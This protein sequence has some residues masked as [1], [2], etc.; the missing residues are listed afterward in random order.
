M[1]KVSKVPISVNVTVGV[2]GTSVYNGLAELKIR[3]DK[4]GMVALIGAHFDKDAVRE[5]VTQE[6]E[7]QL[8]TNT[9]FFNTLGKIIISEQG[10]HG[11]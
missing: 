6:I 11:E 9:S 1:I 5:S 7:F 10:E 2:T 8:S 3:E 4:D